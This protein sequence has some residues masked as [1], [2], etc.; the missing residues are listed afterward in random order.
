[1]R[2]V[3][4]TNILL[5]A[6]LTKGGVA[7]QLFV[8]A[9]AVHAVLSSEYILREA[10]E[11]LSDKLKVPEPTVVFFMRYLRARMTV[12]DFP[13]KVERIDFEDLK[14]VPILYF[15][16]KA[17]AHYFVTGDKKLLAL[18][19]HKQTLFLSLREA[20]ELL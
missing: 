14:D 8:R 10:H 2:V 13:D 15:L 19:K 18:K 6:F 5:S 1:M 3:F 9:I 7:Q 4:D 12:F 11:K 20:L 16:E 17:G